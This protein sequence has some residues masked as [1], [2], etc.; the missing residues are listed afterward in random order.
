MKLRTVVR[1]LALICFGGVFVLSGYVLLSY[2]GAS[3]AQEKSFDEL[4]QM[5]NAAEV[6]RAEDDDRLGYSMLHTK[7]PD[8][9]G[10]VKIEGTELSY[11]VMYTPDEPEYYLNRDFD[12]NESASG[13]P[14]LD[15]DCTEQGGNYLIHSHNM[16]SGT[17]FAP[18]LAYEKQ[19]YC[20]AHPIICFDTLAG[21]GQ[22][23]VIAA[24]YSE[25]YE[26]SA[27][28]VFRYYRYTDLSSPKRFREYVEQVK[29]AA[30]YDTGRVAQYGDQL[31][32][33]ST[34]SYHTEGGRFVVVARK[35]SEVQ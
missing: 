2:Y 5:V 13:V 29:E 35:L 19:E 4:E 32:T 18:L 7:N 9:F 30:L 27:Q 23:E 24:F 16:K 21:N 8:F 17:M 34:C 33:L 31:L 6:E 15:G 22:Y 3:R 10:W 1:S 14:F 12:G 26:V 28:D 11:P 25:V 20:E